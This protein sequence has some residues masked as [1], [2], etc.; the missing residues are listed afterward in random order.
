MKPSLD[1]DVVQPAIMSARFAKAQRLADIL[2]GEGITHVEAEHL[3]DDDWKLV[4]RAARVDN[5]SPTTHQL[6]IELLRDR[7]E[8]RHRG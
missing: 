6:T 1:E 5:A 4:H 7:C 3:S 8:R 2:E